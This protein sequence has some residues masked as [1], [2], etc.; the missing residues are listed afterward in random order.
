M[1]VYGADYP[2]FVAYQYLISFQCSSS[3]LVDCMHFAPTNA[4][5][6]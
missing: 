1:A 3:T 2:Q 5:F 6:Y 4:L